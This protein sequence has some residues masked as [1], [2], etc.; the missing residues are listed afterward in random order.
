MVVNIVTLEKQHLLNIDLQEHQINTDFNDDEY[1]ESL[2]NNGKSYAFVRGD[3][4]LGACGFI[5]ESEDR[6]LMWALLAKDIKNSFI[7]IHKAVKRGIVNAPY[8]RVYARVHTEFYTGIIWV[9]LLGLKLEGIERQFIKGS[10]FA[11]FSKIK[12]Q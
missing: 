4:V 7:H 6:A 3:M 8:N 11:I 10:D 12:G 2:L 1:V 9:N 5:E